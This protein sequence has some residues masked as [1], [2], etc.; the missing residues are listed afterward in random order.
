[1]SSP[2][3]KLDPKLGQVAKGVASRLAKEGALAVLLVGSFLRGDA[4]KESD[5]DLIVIGG[6]PSYRLE[7]Q[8]QYL[9]SISWRTQEQFRSVLDDPAEAVGAV[10][11]WRRALILLDSNAV[12]R[13]LQEQA[14]DWN[15]S[16]V[17]GKCDAWV[18]EKVTGYAEDVQKLLGGLWLGRPLV[19]AAYRW[20]LA[21]HLTE[22]MAVHHRILYEG[23]HDLFERVGA[24]MRHRWQSIQQIASGVSDATFEQSCLAAMEMYSIAGSEVRHLLDERQTAV[25]AHACQ[26]AGFP[27][28]RDR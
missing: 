20:I 6:G 24:T 26:V 27:L 15:W 13:S 21:F 9:F 12:G 14:I 8:A 18:S 3:E 28:G 19:A 11:G 25:V 23:D 10:L 17:E 4:H 5:V 22:V 2:T 7:R 16:R 1:M